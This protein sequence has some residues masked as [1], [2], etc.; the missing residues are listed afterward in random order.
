ME[1]VEHRVIESK[2]DFLVAFSE[3]SRKISWMHADRQF[4]SD[5]SDNITPAIEIEEAF[6][7]VKN[8]RV[9]TSLETSA[10]H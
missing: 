10:Q 2:V 8:I 9:L 4:N 1:P 3:R 5:V 6:T 7:D